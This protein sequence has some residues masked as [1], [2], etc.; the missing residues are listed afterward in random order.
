[1]VVMVEISLTVRSLLAVAAMMMSTE[2]STKD[3][4]SS[5]R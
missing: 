2:L 1:M 3:S 5:S 4:A